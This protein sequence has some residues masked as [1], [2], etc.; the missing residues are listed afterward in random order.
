MIS[1]RVIIVKEH[2]LMDPGTLVTHPLLG[3]GQ[4]RFMTGD[5]A[6]VEFQHE[7]HGE[8]RWRVLPMNLTEVVLDKPVPVVVGCESSQ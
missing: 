3:E 5:M 8:T 1:A 7:R 6:I 2:R 4:F